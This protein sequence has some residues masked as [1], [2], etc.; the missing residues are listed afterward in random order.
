MLKVCEGGKPS[1]VFN[2]TAK[3]VKH[4]LSD[5]CPFIIN[6]IIDLFTI[7]DIVDERSQ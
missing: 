2:I 4:I 5:G 1:R 6:R 7:M 3:L